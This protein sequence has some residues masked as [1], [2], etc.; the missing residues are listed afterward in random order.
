MQ[1]K[2]CW[3]WWNII[4]WRFWNNPII[5]WR[6]V[7]RIELKFSGNI[8]VDRVF[9]FSSWCR[10]W[11]PLAAIT[12]LSRRGMLLTRTSIPSWVTVPQAC[13]KASRNLSTVLGGLS[14]SLINSPI[15]SEICSMR[16]RSGLQ[17]G[18]CMTSTSF[19]ARKM[20]V[21]RAVWGVALSCTSMVFFLFRASCPSPGKEILV[22]DANVVLLVDHTIYHHQLRFAWCI[23]ST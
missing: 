17:A 9:R 6:A 8:I 4:W 13:N 15:W 3:F 12:A 5:F 2:N 20:C 11:P 10:V 19:P 21:F 23:G 1:V 14:I 18:H 7:V 16:F 22:Q